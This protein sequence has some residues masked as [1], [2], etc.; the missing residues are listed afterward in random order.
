MGAGILRTSRT[1]DP[2]PDAAPW[3][4]WPDPDP[5]TLPAATDPGPPNPHLRRLGSLGTLVMILGAPV[6]LAG[7]WNPGLIWPGIGLLVLG[8]GLWF[9]AGAANR[10]GRRQDWRLRRIAEANGWRMRRMAPSVEQPGR[11][12]RRGAKV[13]TDPVAIWLH[14]AFPEVM[15]GPEVPPQEMAVRLVKDPL[16]VGTHDPKALY[17]GRTA[18]GA[19]VALM[20]I[21]AETHLGMAAGPLKVDGR[22]RRADFALSFRLFAAFRRPGGAAEGRPGDPPVEVSLP[23]LPGGVWGDRTVQVWPRP[24]A[25][26]VLGSERIHTEDPEAIARELGELVEAMGRAAAEVDA[27]AQQRVRPAARP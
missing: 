1:E 15:V 27:A 22:G 12:G 8:L 18:S 6:L 24:E 16:S 17:V 10:D 7:I 26:W 20:L 9:G 4:P 21:E 25:L 13:P 11:G 14:A 19:E 2:M 3:A 5:A 23:P